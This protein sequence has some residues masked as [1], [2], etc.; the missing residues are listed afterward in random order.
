MH[1]FSLG[2]P[3]VALYIVSGFWSFEVETRKLA[4]FKYGM[5]MWANWT[6]ASLKNKRGRLPKVI[7]TIF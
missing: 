6:E 4:D 2:T 5:K 1:P 3:C 7:E